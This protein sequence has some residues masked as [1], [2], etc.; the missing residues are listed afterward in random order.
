MIRDHLI[1]LL[2]DIHGDQDNQCE[3]KVLHRNKF[4]SLVASVAT[5]QKQALL[6]EKAAAAALPGSSQVK[7]LFLGKEEEEAIEV[8]QA[9]QK[10]MNQSLV[11]MKE[12]LKNVNINTKNVKDDLQKLCNSL[13]TQI[14]IKHKEI[15]DKVDFIHKYHLN[16]LNQQNGLIQ[17]S[18]KVVS[19]VKL[20]YSLSLHI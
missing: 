18:A 10:F 14:D 20:I 7:L 13:K 12:F 3:I 8:I 17:E 5:E 2:V 6:Q 15:I 4:A 1:E 9:G 11:K 19:K 16:K